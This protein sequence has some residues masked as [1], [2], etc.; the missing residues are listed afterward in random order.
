MSKPNSRPPN[1]APKGTTW[2]G[3]PIPW[4]SVSLLVS[5]DNLDPDEVTRLLGIKPDVAHRSDSSASTGSKSRRSMGS[6]GMWEICLRYEETCEADLETAIN[7]VLNRVNVTTALWQEV[8]GKAEA[9]IFVGLTLDSYNRGFR[10]SSN[11]LRR[12]ADLGVH[13]DFNIYAELPPAAEDI[14]ERPKIKLV[15]PPSAD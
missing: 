15:L 9:R 3:G 2:F 6:Q 5:G 10:I 8:V 14:P 12:V 7:V 11:L 1:G 13:L 4:F